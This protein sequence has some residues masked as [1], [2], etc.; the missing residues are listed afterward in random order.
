MALA[1]TT[2]E[3]RF[4][5]QLLHDVDKYRKY[6]PVTIFDDNQGSIALVENPV[7]YQRSKHIDIKYHFVRDECSQGRIKVMHMSSEEM[8]ADI[9][10]KPVFR[11]K[12]NQ[13]KDLK[14]GK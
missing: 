12:L 10:T 13:F 4:L 8:I 7:N 9:L 11:L 14:F 5:T 3:C 1:A 2:Q 6:E